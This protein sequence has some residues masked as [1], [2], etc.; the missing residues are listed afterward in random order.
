MSD[1]DQEFYK[2]VIRRVRWNIFALGLVGAAVAAYLRTIQAGLALLIGAALSYLSFWGWQQLVNALSPGAKKR[3]P[4]GFIARILLLVA[5]AYAVVRFL[6]LNVAVAAMG[7]LVSAAAVL[8]ELVYE[9]IYT[10][11]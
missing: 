10:R 9:L 8:A 2:K 7:L 11:T 5:L 4:V 3:S 6:G 1:S